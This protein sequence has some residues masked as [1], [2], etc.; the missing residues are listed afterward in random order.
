MLKIKMFFWA[1][2]PRRIIEFF[3]FR[4]FGTGFPKAYNGAP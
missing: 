1:V 3:P 4:E 2:N